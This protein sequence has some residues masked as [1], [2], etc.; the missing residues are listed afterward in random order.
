MMPSAWARAT[1][2]HRK[3]AC[4]E[5]SQEAQI[6]DLWLHAQKIGVA[7]VFRDGQSQP[8]EAI[9]VP[10]KRYQFLI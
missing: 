6:P 1:D 8:K 3:P 2:L 9:R 4:L 7:E 5:P 10:R